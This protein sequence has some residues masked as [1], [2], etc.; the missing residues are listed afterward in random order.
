MADEGM[1]FKVTARAGK[2][3]G[4]GVRDVKAVRR[5]LMNL[6]RDSPGRSKGKSGGSVG[7][8]RG[9]G[10]AAPSSVGAKAMRSANPTRH[11]QRAS[12]RM[13]FAS[14]KGNGQWKAHGRYIARESAQPREI[15]PQLS[16][17]EKELDHDDR[18]REQRDGPGGSDRY[19]GRNVSSPGRLRALRQ[20]YASSL[21]E[22]PEATSLNGVRSLSSIGMVGFRDTGEMLLQDHA[23]SHLEH[24]GPGGA[25]ALR[26]ASDGKHTAGRRRRHVGPAD[27]FGSAGAAVPIAD[28]L[29]GWQKAGDGNMFKFILSPEF[30][31]K[32]NLRAYTK[33][34]VTKLESDLGTRLEWVG[35]DHYNTEHPHVHLA[36][37]GLDQDGKALR[38]DP[39]YVK[40]TMRERAQQVAT[41]QLGFRTDKDV[42]EALTRQIDQQRYTELDRMILKSAKRNPSTQDYEADYQGKIPLGDRFAQQREFRIQQ[43]KRLVHLEQMGLAKRVDN[44]KWHLP[45]NVE[46]ALRQRQIGNDRLKTLFQHRAML[47]DPR[48][49]MQNTDIRQAGRIAGRLIGTGLDESNDRPYMLIEGTDGKVHYIYQSK[50][51]EQA[52]AAGLRAG[53]FVVLS[54]TKFNG[55]DG[56]ERV[57]VRFETYGDAEA[58]LKDPKRLVAETFRIVKAT[59]QLPTERAYGGWLGQYHRALKDT[60]KALLDRGVIR[61]TPDGYEAAPRRD[62]AQ[63]PKRRGITR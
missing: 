18:E 42:T 44:M 53:E 17:E 45:H 33:D 39:A 9:R 35:I 12:V 3:P 32:M 62:P 10:A 36:V 34:F 7:G 56:K 63:Q 28:T 20:S 27:G 54:A 60:G 22:R 19:S 23:S 31:D 15:T 40:K 5:E 47:S 26:R 59:K 21:A 46:H 6:F 24:G 2:R 51:A 37:R 41:N 58:L 16:D 52:R 49:Q 55:S 25:D 11:L 43:I 50:E 61:P 48:L 13:T 57:K 38:I 14:N 8:A 4:S 1:K 30:G 29:D